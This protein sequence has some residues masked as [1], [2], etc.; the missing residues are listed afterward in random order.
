VRSPFCTPAKQDTNHTS[1]ARAHLVIMRTLRTKAE[2]DAALTECASKKQLLVVDFTASWCGP[3]QRIAPVYEKLA[4]E[5][6]QVMFVKV[7]VDENEETSAACNVSAMPTFKGYRDRKETFSVRGADEQALRA[8]VAAQHATSCPQGTMKAAARKAATK[9]ASKRRGETAKRDLELCSAEEHAFRSESLLEAH[10]YADAALEA[11]RALDCL[12]L[13]ARAALTRGRALL[14]PALTKMVEEGEVPSMELLDQAHRAFRLAATLDPQDNDTKEEIKSLQK[15]LTELPTPA[16]PASVVTA[17]PNSAAEFDV[18]I[19]GA[20]AAGVGTA[21]M[22]TKTFGLDPS[23]VLLIE[24]GEAVGESFRRWPAEMRFISPSFNQQGWTSSFDLNS[25]AHGTSPA[26]SLHAE[27]PSGT[28][29]ANY[30]KQIASAADLNVRTQAEVTSV[31]AVGAKGGSPLFH[32]EVRSSKCKG[33][34]G[35]GGDESAARKKARSTEKLAAR[36]IVWA[37]GEFQYPRES[38]CDVDG[39]EFCVHNSRVQSWA[40]LPGNDRVVI[41]GYESGVDAAVNLARAGKQVTVLASTS[42][43][44]VQTPDPSTELAPYTAARLREVTA[45]G[46]AS[47]P[48]LLAPL[49]VLRVEKAAA[50]GFNVV[51]AWRAVEPPLPAGPLRK[52]LGS[53]A[54]IDTGST[55][56]A[57]GSELVV[58]TT[59]PPVLCT[60]FEGSV[61]SAAGHLFDF[62]G[63][64]DEAKGCLAGAPLLTDHDESTKVPGVFLVGP[65]VRHGEHSFCFVYKFR[66][67]F[68]IV[69]HAICRGLGRRDADMA[70][71]IARKMNMYLD[72]LKC[73]ES[74]CGETC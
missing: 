23:R 48:K 26:Y 71:D 50:G 74:T 1:H 4:A 44:N 54:G 8:A 60:G 52:P 12:P 7:D 41:G 15:V 47:H 46:F 13:M 72:D 63:P 51:A 24:R 68:G 59:Q 70:V 43:W 27:H 36:Y 67:R 40:K 64:S 56:R 58:H 6:E 2:F 37:A 49:R 9:K 28:E 38:S 14:H 35:G 65:T 32:V 45:P 55:T 29:Y 33:G 18:I 25:V 42:T 5:F 61:A 66:Q 39:A 57:E 16:V 22:L 3:C 30:L 73:C 20:G 21:L 53:A 11:E 62:A 69:A 10:D 31:K 19:I 17:K 34:S